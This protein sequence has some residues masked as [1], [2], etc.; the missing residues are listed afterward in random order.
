MDIVKRFVAAFDSGDDEGQ[1]ALM[2]PDIELVEWPEAPDSH[3]VRGIDETERIRDSWF[4]AWDSL[5]FVVEE[6]LEQGDRVVSCGKAHAMGKGSTVPI[7]FENYA[8]FTVR[9]GK[10]ARME[11]FI[12]RGQ[13]LAAAGMTQTQEAQ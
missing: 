5:D 6:Y 1:R 10:V 3:H 7:D 4:E 11:F 8:V 12:E 13:A 2:H 9:D